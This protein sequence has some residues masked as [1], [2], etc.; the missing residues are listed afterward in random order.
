MENGDQLVSPTVEHQFETAGYVQHLGLTKREH[1]AAMAMQ[2]LLAN[3]Q[4]AEDVGKVGGNGGDYARAALFHAD[5]LLAAL[6][7]PR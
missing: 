1:F 3:A 7:A 5:A 6:D 2:G 4:I